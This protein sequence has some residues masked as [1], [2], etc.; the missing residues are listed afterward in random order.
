LRPADEA[1]A[2]E[3][4]AALKSE[5]IGNCRKSLDAYKVP[6]T[7]RFVDALEMTTAGKLARRS[8]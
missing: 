4:G 1:G 7:I 8:A 3:N 5:L 2:A 6:A